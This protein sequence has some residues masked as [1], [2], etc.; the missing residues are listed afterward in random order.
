M[1]REAWRAEVHGVSKEL[2]MTE[3]LNLAE[4]KTVSLCK[5]TSKMYSY[6]AVTKVIYTINKFHSKH[7]K[8]FWH[9]PFHV[10]KEST[11]VSCCRGKWFREAVSEHRENC[12]FNKLCLP[13]PSKIHLVYVKSTILTQICE[14]NRNLGSGEVFSFFL[15][16]LLKYKISCFFVI[17]QK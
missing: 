7:Q 5:V 14:V 10:L 12:K 6:H 4:L 15:P 17:A 11:C 9:L 13:L 16:F 2:D 3:W 8:F 1:D